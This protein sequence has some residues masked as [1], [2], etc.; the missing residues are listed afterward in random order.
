MPSKTIICFVNKN[1]CSKILTKKSEL[2]DMKKERLIDV[3]L[4]ETVNCSF[5]Q[6]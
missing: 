1:F 6:I 2:S 5:D 4:P 3:G